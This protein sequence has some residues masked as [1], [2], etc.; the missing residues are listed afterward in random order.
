MMNLQSLEKMKFR[1]EIILCL[2]FEI[3]TR[4]NDSKIFH[5]FRHVI[6]RREAKKSDLLMIF[7]N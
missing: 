6:T 4:I 3:N 1:F 7:S 2:G 5:L